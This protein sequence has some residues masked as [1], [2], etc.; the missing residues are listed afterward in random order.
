MSRA[1][2]VTLGDR[3]RLVVPAAIRERHGWKQGSVL[4]LL[5]SD[6][7]V[8]LMARDQLRQIVRRE[9]AG[10]NLVDEL[11]SERRTVATTEDAT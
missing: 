10:P 11:L 2:L 8:V 5:D 7:G 3:G 9:L 6:G 4:V 1:E